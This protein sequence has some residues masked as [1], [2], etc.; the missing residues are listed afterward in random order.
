VFVRRVQALPVFC[1]FKFSGGLLCRPR[2]QPGRG[3]GGDATKA[4]PRRLTQ[5]F[6]MRSKVAV[7]QKRSMAIVL[8]AVLV[9]TYMVAGDATAQT[10]DQLRPSSAF[11]NIPD[12]GARSRALFGEAAEVITSPRCMNCHPAG[13]QPHQGDDQHVHKPPAMRGEANIGVPGL[14]CAACH[15]DKNFTLSVGEASYQ[16]IPG[17]PRWGLA[18]IEMAWEGKSV[19]EICLQIKDPARN[20]GRDLALL[21][22][23]MAKDDLV[24]WGWHPGAGRRPAPGTQ[25]Q[26]GA[27]IQAWINTGAECP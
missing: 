10:P 7:M 16:S 5:R 15:T 8:V 13:N 18:P 19:G 4:P 14:P 6:E 3:K 20:G 11:S 9:I 22:E 23:H 26:F 1:Y 21:L 2:Y 12:R 17:H 27:I 24:A 25:E